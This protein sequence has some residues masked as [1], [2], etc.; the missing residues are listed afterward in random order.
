MPDLPTLPTLC[1]YGKK[2]RF[3]VLPQLPSEL[4]VT[5]QG[6]LSLLILGKF[7]RHFTRAN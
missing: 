3:Y 7:D 5:H 6:K 1:N 2:T 4:E